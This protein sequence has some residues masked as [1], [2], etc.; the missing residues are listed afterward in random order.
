MKRPYKCTE[1]DYK[2]SQK[3]S[4]QTHTRAIHKGETFPCPEWDF[5]A[6]FKTGFIYHINSVHKG[7]TFQC[8]DCDYKAT[9]NREAGLS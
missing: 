1:C 7:K 3:V 5:K 4:L 9:S 8:P 6:K 2:A